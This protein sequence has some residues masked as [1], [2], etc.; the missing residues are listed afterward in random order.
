MINLEEY[1]YNLLQRISK[2]L[3][4]KIDIKEIDDK[5]YITNE[6]YHSV[7]DELYDSYC[8]LEERIEDME[9]DIQENYEPKKFDPYKEYGVSK[10]DFI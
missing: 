7:M 9:Y 5:Y 8:H 4:L 2:K 1:E 10:N 6:E 3:S